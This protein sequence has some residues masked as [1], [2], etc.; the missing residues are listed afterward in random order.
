MIAE[1]FE[2][3]KKAA[4][5]RLFVREKKNQEIHLSTKSVDESVYFVSK[6]PAHKENITMLKNST[7]V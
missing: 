3:L 1:Q 7:F 2:K 6:S 5:G 4:F